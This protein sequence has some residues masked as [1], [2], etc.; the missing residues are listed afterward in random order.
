MLKVSM[1]EI[2]KLLV[3]LLLLLQLLLLLLLCSSSYCSFCCCCHDAES[4]TQQSLKVLW[5]VF[6]IWQQRCRHLFIF[7]RNK[8]EKRSCSTR[9]SW[10]PNVKT[11]RLPNYAKEGKRLQTVNWGIAQRY[12]AALLTQPSRVRILPRNSRNFLT[13][14]EISSVEYVEKW[15]DA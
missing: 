10:K 1:T 14:N 3:L 5:A 15:I 2:S 11:L 13:K 7:E 8:T 12:H 9:V 4:S 6:E